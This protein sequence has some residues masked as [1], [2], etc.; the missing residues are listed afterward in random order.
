MSR[1]FLAELVFGKY[2][3]WTSRQGTAFA[4]EHLLA[5]LCVA[6]EIEAGA[7]ELLAHLESSVAGLADASDANEGRSML[8]LQGLVFMARGKR[9]GADGW[10]R[11]VAAL[12]AGDA[13]APEAGTR[14]PSG[15]AF[16][17]AFAARIEQQPPARW[18][19][20]PPMGREHLRCFL[21]L[22][23]EVPA[24]LYPIIDGLK[25]VAGLDKQ[26]LP[27]AQ[28]ER[29]RIALLLLVR[30]VGGERFGVDEMVR[31]VARRRAHMEWDDLPAPV[32]AAL[33]AERWGRP[34][35]TA[36][37]YRLASRDPAQSVLFAVARPDGTVKLE[38]LLLDSAGLPETVV[39][40][41]NG[42]LEGYGLRG[43][44]YERLGDAG[45]VEAYK[46]LLEPVAGA[47]LPQ[48]RFIAPDGRLLDDPA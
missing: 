32:R 28:G 17:G 21:W 43:F 25:G 4:D 45:E 39:R 19:L 27:S 38:R 34:F 10:M 11:H 40:T 44:A 33:P 24:R 16:P 22:A 5:L 41:A 12:K 35:M 14:E 18:A 23:S 30:I 6:G 8:A 7:R 46:V 9:F 2:T 48:T 31:R 13:L 26:R 3:R 42:V 1:E 47:G 36:Q 29:A 15:D 37:G 20:A